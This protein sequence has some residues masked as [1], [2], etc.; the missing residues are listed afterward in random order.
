MAKEKRFQKVTIDID[1][2]DYLFLKENYEGISQVVRAIIF[3]VNPPVIQKPINTF[4]ADNKVTSFRFIYYSR[5]L[6]LKEFRRPHR[7]RVPHTESLQSNESCSKVVT[8][9]N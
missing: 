1:F 5:E 8:R 2:N 3:V 7:L 9:L 4:I 6:V